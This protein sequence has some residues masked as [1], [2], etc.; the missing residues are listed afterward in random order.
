MK[1]QKLFMDMPVI[2]TEEAEAALLFAKNQVLHNLPEFTYKFQKAYSVDNFY[3]PTEN[4]DWTTGF[5][6]GEIWLSYEYAKEY[7]EEEAL[8]FRRAGEIQVDSFLE[9]I[10]KKIEVEHHDMGFLYTLSCV[11][12]YK[13]TGDEKAKETD[14][15][16]VVGKPHFLRGKYQ[17]CHGKETCP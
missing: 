16:V 9:R 12:A 10:D 6:T 17:G 4:V 5:W 1:E 15:D 13:L 2:S 3:E 14:S 8:R 11:A 7:S